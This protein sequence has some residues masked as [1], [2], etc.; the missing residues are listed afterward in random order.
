MRLRVAVGMGLE[1]TTDPWE[2]T[3]TLSLDPQGE[4]V[5]MSPRSA[6]VSRDGAPFVPPPS[7]R[8]PGLSAFRKPGGSKECLILFV[9][10]H[11]LRL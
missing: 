6:P 4:R 5:V 10:E 7:G 1:P 11:Y 9:T 3:F 8:Q 2:S